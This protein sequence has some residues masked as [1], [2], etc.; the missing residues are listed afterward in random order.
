MVTSN[1]FITILSNI[2]SRYAPSRLLSYN[3]A[4]VV[5]AIQ[6]IGK[7]GVAS[8]ALLCKDLALG[9]GSIKTLVRHMRMYGIVETSRRGTML[10]SNGKDLYGYVMRTIPREASIPCCSIAIGRA[11]YAVRVSSRYIRKGIGKGIEQRDA[12][13]KVGALGATTLMYRN[14]RFTM[15]DAYYDA[16]KDEHGVKMLLLRELSPDDGDVIVIGSADYIKVAEVAA[17]YAIL[18]TIL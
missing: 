7:H 18:S 4:H 2:A 8:R 15:P 10:T 9:E 5:I 11:N 1:E 3:I 12:A 14:A 16:L 17:K 13:V 6:S